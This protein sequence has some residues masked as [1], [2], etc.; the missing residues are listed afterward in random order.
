ME[1]NISIPVDIGDSVYYIDFNDKIIYPMT[2][3]QIRKSKNIGD[4]VLDL[5]VCG[6]TWDQ[7]VTTAVML[8]DLNKTWFLNIG[9]AEKKLQQ[10]ANEMDLFKKML[11]VTSVLKESHT[12][13][14]KN[15]TGN[16][17]PATLLN[18]DFMCLKGIF[19]FKDDTDME[20]YFDPND[21]NKK[22]IIDE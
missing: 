4:F 19:H 16:F 15:I 12:F 2:V 1:I 22:F 9:E 5:V 14:V 18:L 6:D 8:N 7:K 20:Y 10:K 21:L 3:F 17:V 11:N 13:K